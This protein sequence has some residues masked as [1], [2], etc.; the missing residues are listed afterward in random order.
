MDLSNK[1]VLIT[2]AGGFIGSHI[3]ESLLSDLSIPNSHIL[4]LSR[5]R[6]KLDHILHKDQINFVPCDLLD[7]EKISQTVVDFNP[8]IIFHM[9]S[10]P[11]ASEGFQQSVDTVDVNIQGTINLLDAFTKSNNPEVIV[12]G[13]SAKV[14]GTNAVPYSSKTPVGPNSSYAISKIAGW[15]YAKLFGNLHGFNAVSVRPTLVYGARQPLNLIKFV[16]NCALRGDKSITLDGGLQT[17]APL[18]IDDAVDAY[19]LSLE[20]AYSVHG[21]VINVSGAE[22]LSVQLIANTIIDMM[23]ADTSII[24]NQQK[25]RPTEMQRSYSDISEAKAMIGWSPK[26]NLSDG[27]K[28]LIDELVIAA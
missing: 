17:R 20:H 4:A 21:S 16:I 7:Q 12:Y 15:E 1:R 6:G 22:E 2:G 23:K 26:F 9:A 24:I 27:L 13:D 14:Y 5:K 11:D 18:Y 19:L 25:I 10:Q 28:V 3:V 8:H